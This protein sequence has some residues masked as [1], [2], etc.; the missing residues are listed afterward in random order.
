MMLG[1]EALLCIGLTLAAPAF[2][3]PPPGVVPTP[4]LE[5]W[6][7]SLKQPL[8][9]S[10]CCTISDCRMIDFTFRDGHYEVEIE[11]WRYVVPIETIL[12]G[13][14]NPIG[15]AVVC[16]THSAFGRSTPPDIISGVT[17]RSVHER[18]SRSS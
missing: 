1:R 6:F 9:H 12:D 17:T 3:T 15:G 2:A 11:G 7:K 5:A 10:P 8:T 14:A 18:T 13:A 16:Y 4:E